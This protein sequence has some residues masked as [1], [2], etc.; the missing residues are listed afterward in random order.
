[1]GKL[2]WRTYY[3][4]LS[5]LETKLFESGM[6]KLGDEA[7]VTTSA[8]WSRMIEILDGLNTNH[9]IGVQIESKIITEKQINDYLNNP[10][11]FIKLYNKKKKLHEIELKEFLS[12]K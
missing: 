9:K 12:K 7:N 5:P 10:D 6:F 4:N 2:N 8:E 1:M 11:K 3:R